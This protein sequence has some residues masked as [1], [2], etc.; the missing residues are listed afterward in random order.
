MQNRQ[1]HV[2]KLLIKMSRM[3][4]EEVG[5]RRYGPAPLYGLFI[6]AFGSVYIKGQHG[7]ILLSPDALP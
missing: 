5:P 7:V 3:R 1:T 6:T 2:C 4:Q